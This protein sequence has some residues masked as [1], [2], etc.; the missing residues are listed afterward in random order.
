MRLE[1]WE[2]LKENIY[3]IELTALWVHAAPPPP[4]VR[5]LPERGRGGRA[6]REAGPLHPRRLRHPQAPQGAGLAG[7]ASP[8]DVPLH[9]HLGLLAQRRRGLLLRPDPAASPARRVPL[10]RRAAG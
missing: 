10:D 2:R 5:P 8:L 4:G 7:T 9:A 1:K 6:G 3:F